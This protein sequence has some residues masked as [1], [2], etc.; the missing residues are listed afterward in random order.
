M[1]N[2]AMDGTHVHCKWPADERKSSEGSI[3][4]L[5]RSVMCR[6]EPVRFSSEQPAGFQTVLKVNLHESA[7]SAAALCTGAGLL[8]LASHTGS[9]S[10][11]DLNRAAVLCTKQLAEQPISGLS[12]GIHSMQPQRAHAEK[13]AEPAD[14]PSEDR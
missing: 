8:A 5:R 7:I 6:E 3:L 2:S 1:Q 12:I 9:L 4:L 11:I 13:H 14:S 10:L